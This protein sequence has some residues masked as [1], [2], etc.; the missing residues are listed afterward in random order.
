MNKTKLVPPSISLWRILPLIA[1]L[2]STGCGE[3]E[4]FEHA[5][6]SVAWTIETPDG[7]TLDCDVIDAYQ[8]E[9]TVEDA[10]K[11]KHVYYAPCHDL[12]FE[13]T[14]WDAIEG[15]ARITAVLNT[16]TG[17]TVASAATFSFDLTTGMLQ[18]QL[19]N[20][21]F[22][23]SHEQLA[24]KGPAFTF[25]YE[26]GD[27][28]GEIPSCNELGTRYL[29]FTIIDGAMNP[30]PLGMFPC[31]SFGSVDIPHMPLF[32]FGEVMLAVSFRNADMKEVATNEISL[33]F[34]EQEE[35]TAE[36]LILYGP[37]LFA[38]DDTQQQWIWTE[39]DAYMDEA[40]CTALHVERA[41]LFVW[42]ETIAAFWSDENWM[43][44][45]CET[46][47]HSVDKT[48]VAED[49]FSGLYLDGL[50][51]AGDYAFSLGFYQYREIAGG[52]FANQLVRLYTKGTPD[53]PVAIESEGLNL[54]NVPIEETVADNGQVDITL[55]WE[56]DE[57]TFDSC[58][59]VDASGLAIRLSSESG[60]AVDMGFDTGAR[61]RD[62]LHFASL[63][64][65]KNGYLLT[66]V[67]LSPTGTVKWHGKC[68][69]SPSDIDANT[70]PACR[71]GL[72]S[73][74]R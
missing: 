18:N 13:T 5:G 72:L 46:R 21:L 68:D 35:L 16:K 24:D 59:A 1:T 29:D 41:Q 27:S 9:I 71:V 14:D 15:T 2:I 11:Q 73:S 6:F 12:F 64:K 63:P 28:V 58:D 70:P 4:S 40:Q 22:E 43:T 54:F 55:T 17:D 42:N 7:V 56:T 47:S 32:V 66:V 19:P 57:E 33:F 61:C 51:P 30:Y 50:I 52:L 44:S 8:L 38:R 74:S 37:L 10:T 45:P 62:T 34:E 49:E 31:R 67:G 53:A 20:I 25:S 39:N 48:L 65:A 23:I 3:S 60:V 69:L 36:S 26:T